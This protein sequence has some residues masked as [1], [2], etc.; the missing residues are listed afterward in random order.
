[1][2]RQSNTRRKAKQTKLGIQADNTAIYLRVSTDKQAEEGFSIDAQRERLLAYCTAQGWPVAESHI[3]IDA[4]FSGKTTDRPAYQ[5]MLRA[6]ESGEVRRIVAMKLDRLARNVRDFLATVDSLN[7]WGCDMV[8]VKESFDT[9]TPHGKFA[10]TLFSAMAEL[11]AATITERVMSG[12]R[13]KAE[14]GGYNGSRIPL[15]YRFNDGRFEPSEDAA[16]VRRIFQEYV[17]GAALIAIANRLNADQA[18][19]ARGGKWH[20]GTVRY[21]L[22]NGAYAGLCQ[23]A[24]VEVDGNTHPAI[25][26]PELYHAAMQRMGL[27]GA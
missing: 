25:I 17:S 5:A 16:T 13:Q 22:R 6:A 23:W 15:G 14:T 19:T 7:R 10:L 3:F 21:V 11:E 4:G 24:G 20:A 27:Q 12:K 9:S 2:A 26:A 1:M 8:L 18:S